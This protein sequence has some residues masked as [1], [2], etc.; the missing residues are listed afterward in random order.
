MLN[1][2]IEL[3]REKEQ[4]FLDIAK[5]RNT[6]KEKIAQ[7][8]IIEFLEDLQDAKIGEQAYKEYLAN[9]KKSISADNLFKQLNL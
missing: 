9:E 1:L 3:S 2:N 5:A 7:A 8:L 6:S 4:A